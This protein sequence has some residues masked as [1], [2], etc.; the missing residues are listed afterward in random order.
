VTGRIR[1]YPVR[2]DDRG[3]IAGPLSQRR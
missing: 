3:R 2:P 1:V